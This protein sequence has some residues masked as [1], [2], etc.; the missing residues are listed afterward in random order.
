MQLHGYVTG[1]PVTSRDSSGRSPLFENA[2]LMGAAFGGVGGAFSGFGVCA[3]GDVMCYARHI[4]TGVAVGGGVSLI[5]LPAATSVSILMACTFGGAVSALIEGPVNGVAT[6]SDWNN[7][8]AHAQNF[9][10]GYLLGI[11]GMAGGGFS[12]G[13]GTV[14][15]AGQV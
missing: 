5:P 1:S 3:A 6:G 11:A 14:P 13:S 9:A 12:G 7:P 8:Q 4:G 15:T 10:V 2:T